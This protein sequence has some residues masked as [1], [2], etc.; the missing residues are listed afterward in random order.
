MARIR[1]GAKD[2]TRALALAG[3][4]A[5]SASTGA[6]ADTTL[7]NVSLRPDAR[8][9]PRIDTAFAAYWKKDTGETVDHPAVA[10]RLGRA[11]ARGDRRPGRRRGDAGARL[12]HRRHRRQDG[13][14]PGRLAEA[15]ARTTP[16]PTPRR[17]SSW[18]ARATPRA[19]T[20][21]TISPSPASPSSRRTR[22]PRAARAGTILAAWGYGLKQF[23]GDEAKTRDFVAALYKNVPVLDTGARGS[24]ITFAQRGLGDVLIAWENEAHLA[25]EEFGKDKFEIVTPSLSILAEPPV[26]RGRRMSTP[27]ARARSPRPIS[28][29]STRPRRRRSSPQ[30]YYRPRH[31]EVAAKADLAQFP[32]LDLFTIDERSA[33]GPRRRRRTS[34]TAACSTRSRR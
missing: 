9:L 19:S 10:W 18:C 12:R 2:W 14:D 32:K 25:L 16:R 8:A 28:S 13:H 3:L 31:P 27:R 34:P 23:G 11:G 7:L 1:I 26:A 5:L 24:T 17:S 15:P 6:L 33:A 30:N 21:G 4:A 29:S 20:T 22:R